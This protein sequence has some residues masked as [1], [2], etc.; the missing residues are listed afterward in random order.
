MMLNY[1]KYN[2]RSSRGN[3]DPII[4]ELGQVAKEIDARYTCG[5][6]Y[7]VPS[8][9]PIKLVYHRGGLVSSKEWNS[10]EFLVQVKLL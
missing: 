6:K 8:N 2:T 3:N 4:S 1:Q 10:V 7:E 5:G 9:K